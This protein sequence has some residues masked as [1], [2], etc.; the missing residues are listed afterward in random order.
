MI[1]VNDNMC[2]Q[3]PFQAEG[4]GQIDVESRNAEIYR[5]HKEGYIHGQLSR[6][7][8]LS[9][10]WI[11]RICE[12]EERRQNNSNRKAGERALSVV[13]EEPM[14]VAVVAQGRSP[15]VFICRQG[16]VIQEMAEITGEIG[17]LIQE[18]VE[19]ATLSA[20]ERE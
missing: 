11:R 9:P 3:S 4:L 10:E 8:S 20:G 2:E 5:K 17:K 6:E 16:K 7:Y 12:D 14:L 18:C 15:Q 19:M 1:A 13:T